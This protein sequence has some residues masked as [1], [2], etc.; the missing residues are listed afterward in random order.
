V[1][2]AGVLPIPFLTVLV[3]GVVALD[4]RRRGLHDFGA[5]TLVVD[6]RRYRD[7]GPSSTRDG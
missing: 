2:I 1:G 4:S 6:V 7:A 5:G 3:Y